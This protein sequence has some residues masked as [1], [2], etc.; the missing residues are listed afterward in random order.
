VQ[1]FNHPAVRTCVVCRRPVTAEG[2]RVSGS[3]PALGV[4]VVDDGAVYRLDHSYLIG[5]DP[6]SDPTVTG[7]RMRPLTLGPGPAG[8]GPAGPG[9]AG[10]GPAGPGPAVTASHAE[11]RLT[12]WDVSVIDRGSG[13]VTQVLAPGGATWTL[14]RPFIAHHLAP[15]AHIAAG[16]RVVS[17]ISPWPIDAP[18]T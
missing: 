16:S 8:P 14:L 15:G 5:S 11:I 3:R 10:P 4:L 13:G 2:G 17:L 7:G 9:P 6:D 18:V 1:H 12:G